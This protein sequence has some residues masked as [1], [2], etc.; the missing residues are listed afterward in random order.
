MK[1]SFRLF[2][3]TFGVL[4]SVCGRGFLLTANRDLGEGSRGER[5]REREREREVVKC[6]VDSGNKTWVIREETLLEGI[7]KK[8]CWV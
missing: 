5:V 3:A 6:Y 4:S 2:S 7:V 1:K 8:N